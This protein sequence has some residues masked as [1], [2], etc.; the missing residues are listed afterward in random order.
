LNSDQ[1]NFG[2][3]MLFALLVATTLAA[4][5]VAAR[6]WWRASKIA[7][8]EPAASIDDNLAVHH[9]ATVA[10]ITEASGLNAIA[11][12]W[13]AA[14]AILGAVTSAVSPFLLPR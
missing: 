1:L 10:A 9:Y 13:T 3:W 5:L 2:R 4:A 12:R 8:D 11:A 7:V 6:Y 14:A